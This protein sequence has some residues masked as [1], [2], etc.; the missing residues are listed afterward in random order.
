MLKMIVGG[1]EIKI[2]ERTKAEMFDF[3]DH[4]LNLPETRL[5]YIPRSQRVDPINNNIYARF[6]SKEEAKVVELCVGDYES[7]K[8]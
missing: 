4:F 5:K 8:K 1:K 6:Y 2:R 3:L 7:C